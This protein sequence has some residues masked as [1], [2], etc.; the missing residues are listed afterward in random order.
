M[1]NEHTSA[2]IVVGYDGTDGAR[3][4]LD[5]AIAEAAARKSSLRIVHAATSLPTTTVGFFPVYEQVPEV[6]IDDWR[7]RCAEMIAQARHRVEE[8]APEVI[9]TAVTTETDRPAHLLTRESLN[10]AMIVLGSRGLGTLGS[11]FFGSVGSAVAQRAHCPVV[12]VRGPAAA[13]SHPRVVIGIDGRGPAE[14]AIEF[15]FEHASARGLALV[16]TLCVPS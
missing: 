4:A 3:L 16:A 8:L 9:A 11:A 7:R 10:A 13:D 2:P 6:V 14:A 15:A 5:W 1:L 12:V